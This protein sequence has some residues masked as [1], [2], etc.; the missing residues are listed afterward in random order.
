MAGLSA[1]RL[2]TQIL[3]N[4]RSLPPFLYV[5][6]ILFIL[7]IANFHDHQNL[8]DEQER[9]LLGIAATATLPN[10]QNICGQLCNLSKPIIDGNFMG[11]VSSKVDCQ[12]LFS[13]DLLDQPSHHPPLHCTV[14]EV[15][16]S[17]LS[18]E[19]LVNLALSLLL[20]DQLSFYGN[21]TFNVF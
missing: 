5:T 16:F 13:S 2:K 11:S 17:G 8:R 15:E 7:L 10:I 21:T 9:L 14:W 19:K 3:R 20:R 6:I 12:A 18:L 4:L 1:R